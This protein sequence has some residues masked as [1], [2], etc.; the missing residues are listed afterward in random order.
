MPKRKRKNKQTNKAKTN[1]KG[2]RGKK[3]ERVTDPANICG[4]FV[5]HCFAILCS[6]D[7][8]MDRSLINLQTLNIEEVSKPRERRN[9]CVRF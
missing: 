6:W 1:T 3:T 2:H 5:A 9:C 4:A 7:R 8:R